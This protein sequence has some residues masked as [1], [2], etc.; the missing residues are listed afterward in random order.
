MEH[1]GTKPAALGNSAE[2]LATLIPD[3]KLPRYRAWA[4]LEIGRAHV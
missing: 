3:G 1:A 2:S 4:M